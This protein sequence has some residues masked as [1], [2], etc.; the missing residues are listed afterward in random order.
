MGFLSVLVFIL[1]G[2][3]LV[4]SKIEMTVTDEVAVRGEDGRRQYVNQT[5]NAN[6][7]KNVSRSLLGGIMLGSVVVW[8]VSMS[9]FF[10]APGKQYFIV[11][12]TGAKSAI[13]TEG[14]KF[15]MPFSKFQEWDKFID[16]RVA[17]ENMDKEA[18]SELEGVMT[19]VGIRFVDQVTADAY[20]A[21]RFQI[22]SDPESFIETAIKYRSVANL[23]NNTL[24]PTIKEQLLNTGYMFSAQDYISGEA[25]NFRQTFEEQLKYGAYKVKKITILDTIHDDL[26]KITNVKTSYKV[27]KVLENNAPVRIPTE[28]TANN[29]IVSQVILD[30]VDL[31][32]A[33]KKRLEAQRD[34]SAKRQL[35]EQK[36]KTAKTTQQR[37][38][39]EGESAKAAEKVAKETEA[40]SI[41]VAERTKLTQEET[42]RQLAEVKLKTA[43]IDAQTVQ[44]AADAE[45]YAIAKKVRAGITPEVELQMRLD[46]D[47]AKVK[48]IS[49][50]KLPETMFMGSSKGG[51]GI[52]SQLIGADIAKSMKTSTVK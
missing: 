28:I 13:T 47:V 7:L 16:V 31:N 37:I 23:V 30:K 43:K 25:Q 32:S 50:L 29:I 46:A 44:V 33:F 8:F 34:E 45:A 40:I 10:A 42:K 38:I 27:E 17:S 20:P 12:P 26:G 36:V 1:A 6:P 3:A 15:I 51:D 5:R 4:V 21:V 11:S 41:L 22:P 2:I 24:I 35:E 49:N 18:L 19:P 48:A 52:L 39:A 14:I 9:I